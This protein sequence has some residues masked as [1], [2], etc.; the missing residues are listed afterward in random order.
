MVVAPAIF[1]LDAWSPTKFGC[2]DDDGFIQQA[3]LFEIPDQSSDRFVDFCAQLGVIL[4]KFR[5]G[6]PG[7]LAA[8]VEDLNKADAALHQPSGC[9]TLLAKFLSFL[10]V[11]TIHFLC[12]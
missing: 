9:Q 10:L 8:A 4:A 3:T 1:S 5:V 2:P 6:I 11:E 12:F 7:V